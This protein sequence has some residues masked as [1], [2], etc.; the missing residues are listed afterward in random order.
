MYDTEHIC[1]YHLQDVFL[2]TDCLTDEDKD[3]VRNALYRNDILYIFSMEEY[4][5]NILLNLIEELYDRIKN[6]NDLLLIILQLTEKYNNKDPLFGLIIL[7]SFDYLH[8]THKC[9]S[10]FLKCGSI[11]ETD[12]LNLKNTI[13]ENN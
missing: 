3:F 13:N 6:C 5:E 2:E 4:D 11:S 1:N 9:V 8:L 7:H 10:Q 12:L